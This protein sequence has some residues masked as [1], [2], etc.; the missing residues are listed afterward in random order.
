MQIPKF[1][2]W[3]GV[4]ALC[5][6]PTLHADDSPTQAAARAAL[7]QQLQGGQSAPAPAPQSPAK[8]PAAPAPVAPVPAPAPAAAPA[9]APMP[10]TPVVPQAGD[11]AAQAEARAALAK[12][13]TDLGTP[14]NQTPTTAPVAPVATAPA[15]APVPVMAPMAPVVAPVN[16][17]PVD[18]LTGDN[19][20]QAEARA[21]LAKTMADMSTPMNQ[22]QTTTPVAPVAA[23][24]APAVAPATPVAPVAAPVDTTPVDPLT[25][26]SAAQAEARAALAQKM[27]D[28]GTPMNQTATATAPVVTKNGQVLPQPVPIVAPAL[29]ISLAK[30]EKLKVLLSRYMADQVTPEQYQEQ[31]AAILAAP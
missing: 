31:R 29:P 30:E 13:M 4:L 11:N 26:D 9:M 3:I 14:L 1:P 2:L 19:A 15:S 8:A 17:T 22:T 6:G 16:T 12:T 24:P 27:T 25:G 21:A 10:A 7:M 23:A 20:A 28:L 5:G 18:S